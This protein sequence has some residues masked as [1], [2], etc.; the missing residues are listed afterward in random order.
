M[1]LFPP[2]GFGRR[3]I[4]SNLTMAGQVPTA[5]SS[6]TTL[7]R[8][9]SAALD[10]RAKALGEALSPPSPVWARTVMAARN[11]KSPTRDASGEV[12]V[13]MGYASYFCSHSQRPAHL[14]LSLTL[15]GDADARYDGVCSLE[16]SARLVV[17]D[18]N[19]KFVKKHLRFLT[20][21]NGSDGKLSWPFDP[22]GS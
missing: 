5:S 18:R 9:C 21:V 8:A 12:S 4:N 3:T 10:S 2:S 7:A 11:L 19:L 13:G 15:H 16:P 17:L 1:G 6:T 14:N 22:S 20:A